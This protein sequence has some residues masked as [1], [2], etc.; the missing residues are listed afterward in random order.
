MQC[1]YPRVVFYFA[2][3]LLRLSSLGSNGV[4]AR[5]ALAD[6]SVCG[7]PPSCF[8]VFVPSLPPS[9]EWLQRAVVALA[10]EVWCGSVRLSGST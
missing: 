2:L 3:L 5:L 1:P 6:S 9:F 4:C 8:L 7:A 10:R